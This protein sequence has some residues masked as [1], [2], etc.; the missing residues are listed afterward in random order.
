MEK[1]RKFVNV[2]G[3]AITLNLL[4]LV[5]CVPII[6]IGPAWCGMYSAIRYEIRG[7]KW[8][9][10]FKEGFR[11]RFLRSMIA[12][13]VCTALCLYFANNA[14]AGIVAILGGAGGW[15]STIVTCVFLLVTMMLYAAL[16]P[17]NV[18]FD[19]DLNTWIDYAWR[20]MRKAPLQLIAAALLMWFLTALAI[21][22]MLT[23]ALLAMVFIAVYF[24]LS[25]LIMTM[26]L[27]NALIDILHIEKEKH[28]EME[29]E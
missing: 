14:Y 27:K 3:N 25:G 13:I 29:Q 19:T 8:F 2:V 20:L 10:G 1:F 15:V 7:E 17:L 18:Y 21:Y 22:H 24:T 23:V 28:P 16:L 12:G 26:L 5:S 4:F 6:T 9:A 11:T